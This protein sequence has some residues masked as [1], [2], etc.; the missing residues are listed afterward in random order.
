MRNIIILLTV[1]LFMIA[2]ARAQSTASLEPASK[3]YKT[4]A[5]LDSAPT[6]KRSHLDTI[7]FPWPEYS[8]SAIANS[9]L[10]T[11]YLSAEDEAKLPSLISYPANSSD[12]T[13]GE[14]DY[15]LKLQA[16]RTAGQVERAEYIAQIGSTPSIVNP[17]D[18]DYSAN[19]TQLFYIAQDVGEWYNPQHFP[20]TTRLLMNTIQDI[21]ATEFRLK[22]FF[23]RPRPY[24]LEPKLQPLARIG[25]PSF[26]SG[27]TLWA[28]SQAFLFS[29]IIPQMRNEFI[30]R[31]EEVRWSRELMGIH[32]P[33][34]NEASRII[35]WQLL[36]S[37][38]KDPQFVYDLEQAKI[39]WEQNKTKY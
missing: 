24:H 32:Y 8:R 6:S 37:W 20:A 19:R 3:H 11:G 36:E 28:F 4:L 22:R 12:Q 27:H 17:S 5:S 2:V 14:L 30:A 25:S 9:L 1:L 15:L 26:A 21:R 29:E 16:S 33:S 10:R 35:A 39:E 38:K 23:K 13:R 34:D 31:A 18:P 7:S